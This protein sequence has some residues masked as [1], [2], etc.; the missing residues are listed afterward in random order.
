MR[1]RMEHMVRLEP[2]EGK[3]TWTADEY[4]E[5]NDAYCQ[6]VWLSPEGL[7]YIDSRQAAIA[8]ELRRREQAKTQMD[9]KAKED[10]EAARREREK[11]AAEA[12]A[13][14][15]ASAEVTR[16][17][18]QQIIKE[19][20]ARAGHR[21]SDLISERRNMPITRARQIAMW[22]MREETN[23]TCAAIGRLLNKDHTTV[24]HAWKRVDAILDDIEKRGEPLPEWAQVAR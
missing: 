24:L 12:E 8:R 13:L 9:A 14:R 6:A 1:H 2:F 17:T 19:E 16:R 21:P 3:E 15:L 10:A 7:K 11:A 18:A 20:A 4:R 23:K 5:M 22:R